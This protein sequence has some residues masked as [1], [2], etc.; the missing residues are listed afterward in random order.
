MR[1]TKWLRCVSMS[2]LSTTTNHCQSNHQ[3]KQFAYH[4]WVHD[5]AVSAL[6]GMKAKG[7]KA[8]RGMQD[9]SEAA[10]ASPGQ[11]S[12]STLFNIPSSSSAS[13][14]CQVSSFNVSGQS[15]SSNK[16]SKQSQGILAI[17]QFSG[18]LSGLNET[19][20]LYQLPASA[21][22]FALAPPPPPTP[23]PAPTL[24]LALAP[25]PAPAP[26]AAPQHTHV[27]A[28]R[29]LLNSIRED[30][31]LT[32]ADAATMV[33]IFQKDKAAVGSYMKIDNESIMR[34]WVLQSVHVES[35]FV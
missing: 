30:K 27:E 17:N 35:R 5:D 24:A 32:D 10:S 2:S 31:W 8:H 7:K 29:Q 15:S 12:S 14:N 13:S 33:L 4:D 6:V 9:W 19:I 16:R 22:T 23:T 11:S 26:T 18:V 25:T 3:Y 1:G 28:V 20:S 21:S 34:L